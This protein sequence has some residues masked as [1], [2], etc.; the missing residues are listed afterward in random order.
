MPP[1]L[2]W[3]TKY[4]AP[5]IDDNKKRDLPSEEELQFLLKRKFASVNVNC[6]YKRWTITFSVDFLGADSQSTN[7][8]VH[9]PVRLA[10]NFCLTLEKRQSLFDEPV[11]R[12]RYALPQF[13]KLFLSD[14]TFELLDDGPKRTYRL[15]MPAVGKKFV[16]YASNAELGQQ[17]A[18]DRFVREC[19]LDLEFDKHT[20]FRIGRNYL[21]WFEQTRALTLY[22]D[23]F[24]PDVEVLL[25]F[26]AM[27]RYFLDAMDRLGVLR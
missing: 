11:I 20:S 9:C 10:E 13:S 3:F 27:M 15:S 18:N 23:A 17:I 14:R 21:P 8:Y 5:F 22:G 26:H 16:A 25:Q 6:E 24:K 12:D 4:V 1:F 7:L 19:L 2:Q